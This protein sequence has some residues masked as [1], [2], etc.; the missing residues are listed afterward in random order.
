MLFFLKVL[1]LPL[2]DLKTIIPT[3]ACTPKAIMS[4][5]SLQTRALGTLDLISGL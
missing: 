4:L 5:I 3:M 1:L 2:H